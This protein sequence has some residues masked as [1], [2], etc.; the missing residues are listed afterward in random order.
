MDTDDLTE[1]P[2]LHGRAGSGEEMTSEEAHPQR[3]LLALGQGLASQPVSLSLGT[4]MTFDN[5]PEVPW[6]RACPWAR[7]LNMSPSPW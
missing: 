2:G 3:G 1:G 7:S 5:K 4:K 6:G